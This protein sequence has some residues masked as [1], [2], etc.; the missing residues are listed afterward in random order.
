M[1][2]ASIHCIMNAA[3]PP[4]QIAI[5]STPLYGII[6]FEREKYFHNGNISLMIASK[7]VARN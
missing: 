1:H 6:Q 2:A 3:Q 4:F 5:Q 7:H